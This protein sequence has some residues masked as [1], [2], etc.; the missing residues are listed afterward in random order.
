MKI[1]MVR[2]RNVLNTNWLV[3]LANLFASRGHEVVIACDT[4]AKLGKLGDEYTLDETIRVVNL[5]GKTKNPLINIY[6]FLRGKVF[7][8]YIR[9][10]KLIKKEKP[11][12]L[13]CYFPVDLYNVTRFQNHNIPIVQMVHGEPSNVF[14]KYLKA[15][16][17]TRAIYKKSFDKVHTFQILMNSF[18][19]RIKEIT[20][21]K[22]VVRIANP[23]KQYKTDELVDLDNEKKKIIYVGR[24]EKSIKQP[25]LLV[26][27]FA[28]IAK[29]FPDWKVEIWGLAKFENYNN[30]INSFIKEHNMDGQVCLAGYSKDMEALYRTADIQAFPSRSEGFSLAI[31][32]AMAIGLPHVAFDYAFSVNEIVVNNH[33]GF[34]AKDV[35]DFAEK[36]KILMSDKN[37]RI[38]F[39]RNANQDMREYAPDVL[40]DKW[41]ELF[42]RITKG[43]KL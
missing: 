19:N 13:L 24:V 1:M 31:A 4:Y 28:K 8:P 5:N 27:A 34:L 39:G 37:K 21:A 18:E 36:L 26:E 3:Y 33:N 11:D 29:D 20:G 9:F 2:D 41:D 30:E 25:H 35:D 10:N 15:N 22:N 6:R 43:N 38:E 14:K 32:D 16:F 40:L 23:V 7:V 12:I 17:I 42:Y